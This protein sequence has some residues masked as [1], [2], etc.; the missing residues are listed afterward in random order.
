M[1]LLLIDDWEINPGI[2]ILNKS[3][4]TVLNHDKIY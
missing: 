2:K 1:V 4:K 3:M